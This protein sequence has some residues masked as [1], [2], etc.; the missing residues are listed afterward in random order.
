MSYG[1]RDGNFKCVSRAP[2]HLNLILQIVLLPQ[3]ER[4]A[5]LKI[6]NLEV[7]QLYVVHQ[8]FNFPQPLLV[9]RFEESQFM[10]G[11]LGIAR[12]P[13]SDRV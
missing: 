13:M 8:F 11:L 5:L 10:R 4:N 9:L 3:Q 1:L 12:R 7:P 2:A 6:L